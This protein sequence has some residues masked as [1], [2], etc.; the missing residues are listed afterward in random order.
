L[1]RSADRPELMSMVVARACRS[2]AS[3]IDAADAGC[4][5]ERMMYGCGSPG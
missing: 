1:H 5:A 3:G 4:R 2:S